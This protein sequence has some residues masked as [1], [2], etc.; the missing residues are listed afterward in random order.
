MRFE[1]G[2]FRPKWRA[3]AI[4]ALIAGALAV[5][6]G[7]AS[8]AAAPLSEGV[9]GGNAEDGAVEIPGAEAHPYNPY[10]ALPNTTAAAAIVVRR[11]SGEVLGAENPDLRRAPAS[12]TKMMTALLTAEAV[13]AGTVSLSD[14]VKIPPNVNIEGGG[15]VGLV[16]GDAISLRDLL[17]IA[18]LAS[19]NDAA[20]AV[21]TYVGSQPEGH[22]SDVG[23]R[24]FVR[25]MNQRAEELG[26]SNTHYI[27]I[28]GRDPEDLGR[29]ND[30][31]VGREG[32]WPD[33][34]V[35]FGDYFEDP[36][37]PCAHYTSAR[38]L[39]DL[40]RAVLDEPLLARIVQRPSWPTT[41]WR[42]FTGGVR[43][44]T[45]LNTNQLLPG[46]SSPYPGVYG[47][48]TGT[49]DRAKE[50]LVSAA[51]VFSRDVIA[52]VLGSDDTSSPGNRYS[53]SR[54]LLDWGLDPSRWLT[55]STTPIGIP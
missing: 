36:T 19:E 13:D 5:S 26:L 37:S 15:A 20:S 21:G 6:I 29:E 7:A 52:V 16:P 49:T 40:A 4:Y 17:H 24:Q 12:T 55:G 46:G 48:K 51:R 41:T 33:Q 39:A 9:P 8:A 25:Q 53:D 50:N 30:D 43:E 54:A 34:E 27:N 38:D 11:D 44:Y 10:A 32:D 23:R 22:S 31:G 28:A 2:S 35:C 14:T 42:S 45:A 3:V 18:L 1:H 47:V